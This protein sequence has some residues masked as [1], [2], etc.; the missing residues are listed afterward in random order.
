MEFVA[1]KTERLPWLPRRVWWRVSEIRPVRPVGGGRCGWASTGSTYDRSVILRCTRKLLAV[2]GSAGV[3]GAAPV[4]DGEDWYGNLL[5]CERRKCLLVTHAATL[6][7]AVKADVRVS[8][9]RATLPLVVGLI[10]R[11]LVNEGLPADT[12]G[13]LGAATVRIARTAD[14]AVVGCMNDMAYLWQAAVARDGGL[15]KADLAA[16]NRALR[17]NIN[18]SRGYQRPIDLTVDRLNARRP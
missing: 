9:F 8:D 12:F 4:A 6:F 11:E 13:D 18:S 3:D 2:I 14:R 16:V 10:E 17:R 1:T 5:W 15:N 7:T